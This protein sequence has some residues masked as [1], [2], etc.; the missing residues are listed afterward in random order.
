M[1]RAEVIKILKSAVATDFNTK[2]EAAKRFGISPNMLSLTLNNGNKP[3]PGA[4]EYIGY[5]MITVIRHKG[6]NR[7][8]SMEMARKKLNARM[9]EFSGPKEAAFFFACTPNH[10]LAILRGK[11][12]LS[13]EMLDFT[14]FY[15]TDEYEKV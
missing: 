8:A 2:M 3:S 9:S 12:P 7:P 10:L 15:K 14:G 5:E 1:K 13:K 6:S 4:L 11:R